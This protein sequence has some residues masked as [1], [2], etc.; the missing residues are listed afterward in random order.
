M[1]IRLYTFVKICVGLLLQDSVYGIRQ[2]FRNQ[3]HPQQAQDCSDYFISYKMMNDYELIYDLNI[4][5]L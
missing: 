2:D 5:T 4:M 3:A 1:N